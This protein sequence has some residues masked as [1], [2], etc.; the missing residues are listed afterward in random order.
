MSETAPKT[1]IKRAAE[2]REAGALPQKKFYR[3]R[4]HSNPM[5]DHNFEYPL[6]PSEMN[7]RTLYPVESVDFSKEKVRFVDV[8]C[9]YG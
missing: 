9:G 1:K 5:S 2:D 4:A 8:G 3:Q 6:K 7:W